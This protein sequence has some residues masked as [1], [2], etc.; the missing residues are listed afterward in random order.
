MQIPQISDILTENSAEL[1]RF[2]DEFD[3]NYRATVRM[4]PSDFIQKIRSFL[5]NALSSVLSNKQLKL[6][7]TIDT[8]I[9]VQ[10]SIRLANGKASSTSMLLNSPYIDVFAPPN[11]EG[12]VIK[13]LKDK[14]KN[15]SAK[16]NLAISHAKFIL[17]KIKI[18][19]LFSSKAIN[20]ASSALSNVDK[21][22][23]P[24]L[25]VAIET[26]SEAILSHDKKAFGTE[27]FVRR[28]SIEDFAN[29]VLSY[30]EG[31]LAIVVMSE[32]F[33]LMLKV[34]AGLIAIISNMIR[35]IISYMTNFL[36]AIISGSLDILSKLP[37][38]FLWFLILIIGGVTIAAALSES[39][40]S[41]L[42]E[43]L[44]TLWDIIRH[45]AESIFNGLKIIWNEIIKPTI[46]Y[47]AL[48]IEQ[49]APYF[50]VI[51]GVLI[52][53]VSEYLSRVMQNKSKYL[54]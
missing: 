47:V 5:L 37:K 17:S 36:K 44:S 26:R 43:G 21:K 51:F 50:L 8:N 19:P 54:N 46:K 4:F 20:L 16:L 30:H 49:M 25:A 31:T 53:R 24:F 27:Q 35:Q 33:E 14:F 13:T 34:F 39:F 41:Q 15:N 38:W 52:D 6:K 48:L 11:I 40:R 22:D 18:V 3:R 32:T 1:R 9:I 28:W 7:I 12:E 23:V 42:K 45:F 10:D 2:R 29:I